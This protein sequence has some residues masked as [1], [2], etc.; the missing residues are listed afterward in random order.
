MTVKQLLMFLAVF[1][2]AI[3]RIASAK[4]TEGHGGLSV[5]CR[6]GDGSIDPVRTRVLD[7]VEAQTVWGQVVEP[8]SSPV[9]EQLAEISRRLSYDPRLV[10][11]FEHEVLQVTKNI[12]WTSEGEKLPI[13]A[14]AALIPADQFAPCKIEQLAIYRD[15]GVVSMDKAIYATLDPQGVT[16]ILVHEA[17]YKMNRTVTYVNRSVESRQ[18]TARLLASTFDSAGFRKLAAIKLPTIPGAFSAATPIQLRSR[19]SVSLELEGISCLDIWALKAESDLLRQPFK[20]TW[21]A[22]PSCGRL[23]TPIYSGKAKIPFL[24][25]ELAYSL[26]N[27]STTSRESVVLRILQDGKPLSTTE[28]LDRFVLNGSENSNWSFFLM[29]SE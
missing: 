17:I 8:N 21:Y 9:A 13:L 3:P 27:L 11:S 6:N 24:A 4:G 19:S 10:R 15:D 25:R 23:A 2:V 16:A 5:V 14:D 18:L 29:P 12:R 7:I 1:L 28:G 20:W 22:L 26:L